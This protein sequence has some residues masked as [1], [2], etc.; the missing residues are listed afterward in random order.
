M[1]IAASSMTISQQAKDRSKDN[2]GRACTKI[3]LTIAFIVGRL[4]MLSGILMQVLLWLSCE[5]ARWEWRA[6]I[7]QSGFCLRLM[8]LVAIGTAHYIDS[9][10]VI[11][12]QY[13]QKD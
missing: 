9:T 5:Q 2:L 12:F 11:D 6:T 4:P 3:T 13:G 10:Q 8:E 1:A 7:H